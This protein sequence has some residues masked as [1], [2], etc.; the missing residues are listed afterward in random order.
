MDKE[1]ILR[2]LRDFKA[3]R[4]GDFGITEI[5]VFGSVSRD[6]L[7]EDSDVDVFVRTNTPNPFPLVHAKRELERRVGRRVDIVRLRD[8]MNPFLRSRIE[9]EGIRV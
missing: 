9:K 8:S 1:E 5:G 4:A 7:R 3:E 2:E 6:E